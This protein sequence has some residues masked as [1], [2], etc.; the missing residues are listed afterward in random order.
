MQTHKTIASFKLQC[1]HQKVLDLTSFIHSPSLYSK[2]K[3]E[4]K[5]SSPDLYSVLADHPR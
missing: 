1:H 3:Y 4:Q 2:D 5:K